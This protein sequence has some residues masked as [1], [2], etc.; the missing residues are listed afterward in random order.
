MESV[1]AAQRVMDSINDGTLLKRGPYEHFDDEERA[2]ID[3]PSR[4]NRRHVLRVLIELFVNF[5]CV[6]VALKFFRE[7]FFKAK[8]WESTK[9]CILEDK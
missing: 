1:V 5:R 6:P 8:F 7:N 4:E 2:Q 3:H 9:F